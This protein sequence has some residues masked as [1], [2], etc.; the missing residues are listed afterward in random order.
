VTL[1][2]PLRNRLADLVLDG[3]HAATARL[4]LEAIAAVCAAP[5]GLPI[6]DARSD[7][8]PADLVERRDGAIRLRSGWRQHA[9]EVAER[10]GRARRALGDR[11]LDAEDVSLDT[12]LA[13]AAI[14]FDARLYFE[15]HELLEPHWM[16]GEGDERLALQGLI[17]VAVGLYHLGNGNTAGASAL[18]HDGIAKLLDRE[19]MGV[20]L[21][22]FAHALV[23]CLADVNRLGPQATAS[24]DWSRV[25]RFPTR[26]V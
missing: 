13:Q 25:P 2:L 22:A 14:L 1:P 24:F 5:M 15:V 8:C 4:R 12:A 18:L 7:A 11:P 23:G 21:G 9:A 3:F 17:Q 10:A 19:A 16:R 26:R 20:Q 6:D